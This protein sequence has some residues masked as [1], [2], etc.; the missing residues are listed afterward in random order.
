MIKPYYDKDGITIYNGDC[1]EILPELNKVD[2]VV[3]DFPYGLGFDYTKFDDTQENLHNLVQ[4]VMP[5]LMDCSLRALITC[6]HTNIWHY[7]PAKWVMAWVFGTTNQRNSWG[8]TS[9]QPILAY[10][11]DPYLANRVGARMDIINDSRIPTKFEM[12]N[13]PCPKPISF[14]KKLIMRGSYLTT[15]LVLDP[16]MGIG[17]TL[18]A[19]K[20]LNRKCIGIEIEEKYC[21]IAVKRLSQSVMIL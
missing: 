17:T 9:W 1:R 15:D 3:A 10:G 5:L 12:D 2:L 7:P 14:I 13:H 8:F 20:S 19:S 18:V 16:F 11:K 4:E 6:G 21:E